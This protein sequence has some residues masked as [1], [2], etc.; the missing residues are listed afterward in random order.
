MQNMNFETS[1]EKSQI[2]IV[3]ILS[4]HVHEMARIKVIEM[5]AY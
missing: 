1:Y 2:K 5:N 3:H 4:F